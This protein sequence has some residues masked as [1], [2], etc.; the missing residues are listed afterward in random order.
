MRRRADVLLTCKMQ[1]ISR[2]ALAK[3]KAAIDAALRRR[4]KGIDVA[5]MLDCTGSMVRLPFNTILSIYIASYLDFKFIQISY[6]R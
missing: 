4:Q 3:K 1:A 5:V 2:N 6:G